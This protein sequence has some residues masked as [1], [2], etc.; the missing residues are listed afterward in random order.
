[1]LQLVSA[2]EGK[3]QPHEK[4]DERHNRQ[5]LSATFLHDEPQIDPAKPGPAPYELPKCQGDLAEE[6]EEPVCRL[7][8]GEYALPKP[9]QKGLLYDLTPDV[10]AFWHCRSQ[11]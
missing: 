4:T 8:G 9:H 1:M 6:R 11:S 10:L 7:D 3:D 5:R 2:H